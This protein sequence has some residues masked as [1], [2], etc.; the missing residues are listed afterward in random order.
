MHYEQHGG[1]LT[2][3]KLNL[4]DN[5]TPYF[6]RHTFEQILRDN[7]VNDEDR[8]SFLGRSRGNNAQKHYS[9]IKDK[10]IKLEKIKPVRPK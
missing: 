5:F 3:V 4:K 1:K 8:K 9:T 7:G 10:R 2:P 6:A